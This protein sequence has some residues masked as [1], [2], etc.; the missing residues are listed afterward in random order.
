MG[1]ANA[2]VPLFDVEKKLPKSKVCVTGAGGY[3]AAW[4]V[5]RLLRAGHTVHGTVRDP[6][7]TDAYA[8]VLAL[9]GAQERLKLFKADL[10]VAGS[11]DAAIAGCDY[12]IH[13]ASP[14]LLKYP[15]GKEMEYLIDPAVQG[16]RTVLESVNKTSSVKRVVLTSSVAAVYGSVHERGQGY[17][18][19]EKDWNINSGPTSN[20]YAYSKKA[21]EEAGWEMAK[22]Q[23]RWKLVTV[24]PG[25]VLGPPLSHRPDGASVEIMRRILSNELFPVAP[26]MGMSIVDVRDVAAVHCL[27]MSTESAEGR[28]LAI[29]K[30]VWARDVVD[31]L[32]LLFPNRVKK[33]WMTAPVWLIWLVAPLVG[34]T[35]EQV[36][37]HFGLKLQWDISKTT[38]SLGIKFLS[39]V[40]TLRDATEAMLKF[41]LC[42]KTVNE[43]FLG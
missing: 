20:A 10:T 2:K 9:P 11:F 17:V 21:A 40:Q 27:V 18:F 16:T 43:F 15:K 13:C 42:K 23:D 26:P 28:Y 39:E 5:E 22:Q 1:D 30:S 24:N 38:E 29:A 41:G 3:V 8:E 12:V 33:P 32:H 25:F 19:S 36:S 35:R 6:G 31:V 4:I 14:Y 7:K 34:F 37:F